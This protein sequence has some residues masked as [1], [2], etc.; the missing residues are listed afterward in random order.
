MSEVR[1]DAGKSETDGSCALI[2][3]EAIFVQKEKAA[4]KTAAS[5]NPCP[6]QK[7]T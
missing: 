3:P 1:I 7:T 6:F 2:C 4:S 5:G